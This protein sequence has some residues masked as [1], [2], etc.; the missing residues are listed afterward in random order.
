MVTSGGIHG[1]YVVCQG[2][3]EPGDEVLVPNPEWPPA[4]GNIACAHAVPVGYPLH[5]SRGWRPDVDE[6]RRLV[7]SKTRAIYVNSP[8]NPTGGVLTRARPRSHR[9][10]RAGKEPVGDFRRG[11]RGRGLRRRANQHRVAARHV[12]ADDPDLHDEQD[13]RDHRAAAGLHRRAR[14]RRFAIACARCSSTRSR[15]RRRSCST[16]RV[17]AL[18]GSQQAVHD[19]KQELLAPP[20]V[21]L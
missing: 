6:M 12:R 5:E 10:A 7:T 20:D 4:Q 18:A 3:L 8:N 19:F 2:L 14:S 21:V 9:R 1:V 13:V 11:L 15:T 16:A 17:G